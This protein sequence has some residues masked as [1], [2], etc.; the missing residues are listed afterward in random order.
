MARTYKF[1]VKNLHD[2]QEEEFH[3]VVGPGFARL[4][5]SKA[6][7]ARR[8]DLELIVPFLSDEQFKVLATKVVPH[9]RK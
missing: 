6:A 7:E 3:V 1:K 8:K 9:G 5:D 4:L 2:R